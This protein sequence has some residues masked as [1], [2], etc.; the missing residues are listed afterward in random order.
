MKLQETISTL[1]G[2]A[3]TLDIRDEY[4][5]LPGKSAVELSSGTSSAIL[6]KHVEDKMYALKLEWRK[7]AEA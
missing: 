1:V 5:E 7:P 3:F 6:K 2:E 4:V